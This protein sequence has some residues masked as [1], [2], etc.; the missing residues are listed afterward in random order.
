LDQGFKIKL[1]I[2][3]YIFILFLSAILGIIIANQGDT[4]DTIDVE[5]N[6]DEIYSLF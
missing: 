6:V 3:K 5:S 1:N 4:K 2:K